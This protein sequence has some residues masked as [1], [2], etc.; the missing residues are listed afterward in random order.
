MPLERHPAYWTFE[1]SDGERLYYFAPTNVHPPPYKQQRHVEAII[2]IAADGTLAGV[3]LIDGMPPPHPESLM[4]NI[5]P[6]AGPQPVFLNRQERAKMIAFL[7]QEAARYAAERDNVVPDH[8]GPSVAHELGH[9][10]VTL[11]AAASI[12]LG[13]G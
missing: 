10:A 8:N 2:D 13:G 1:E 7:Q 4:R 3:E 11:G 6:D 9:R 5:V 12:L